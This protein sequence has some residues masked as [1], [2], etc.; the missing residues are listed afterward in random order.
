M[1]QRDVCAIGMSA[2]VKVALAVFAGLA[3]SALARFSYG[4]SSAE[5]YTGGFV[6]WL[7]YYSGFDFGVIITGIVLI[8]NWDSPNRTSIATTTF[9]SVT[10]VA[11]VLATFGVF[12]K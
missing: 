12:G 9:L 6:Y 5:T 4:P 7:N 8:V 10:V 3:A 11:A 1:A 2:S